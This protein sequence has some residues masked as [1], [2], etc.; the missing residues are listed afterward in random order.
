MNSLQEQRVEAREIA[1]VLDYT[2]DYFSRIV[3]DLIQNHGMPHPLPSSRRRARIWSR[4][5]ITRWLENYADRRAVAAAAA[6]PLP[7]DVSAER[8]R[9]R[10]AYSAEGA[11][12]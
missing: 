1:A 12:A 11:P 2:P 3:P 10:L 8:A 5:A 9:L 7:A 4:A 6:D